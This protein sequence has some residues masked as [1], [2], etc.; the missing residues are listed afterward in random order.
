MDKLNKKILI[1]V[2]EDEEILLNTLSERLLNEGFEV[3]KAVDGFDGV[4]LALKVHPDIILL[5]LIMSKGDGLSMLKKLHEDA[6]GV[7]AKVIILSNLSDPRKIIG[8]I[9]IGLDGISKYMVKTDWTL[10]DIV[11]EI[12]NIIN[13]K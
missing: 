10:E 12:K 2:I 5:D 7:N 6:W 4:Q 1:L 11:M 13:N 3:L 8:D 9:D